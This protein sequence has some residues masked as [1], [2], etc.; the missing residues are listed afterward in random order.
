MTY[1]KKNKKNRRKIRITKRTTLYFLPKI[2]K[3]DDE[4]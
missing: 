4:Q 3:E 2:L 1:N